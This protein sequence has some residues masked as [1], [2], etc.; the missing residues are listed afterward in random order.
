MQRLSGIHGLRAVAALSIVAFHV[1]YVPGFVTQPPILN[2]IIPQLGLGVPLF[3]VLSAFSLAY[4]HE[5]DVG[6]TG[7]VWPY[8]IKR[9]FRIGPLFWAMMVAYWYLG[10]PP[11]DSSGARLWLINATFI[12]NFFPGL[13][14]SGVAAGWSI[15]I[16]M[17]FY[18]LLPFILKRMRTP[19]HAVVFLAAS[20]VVSAASR[21]WLMHQ[22]GLPA[23]YY[24]MAF[25][26]YLA[27]F[28]FGL[29]AY[30]CFRAYE[31]P[32]V[33]GIITIAWLAL[34]PFRVVT[35]SYTS[36]P[37]D[38]IFWSGFFGLLTLW[39]AARPLRWLASAPMQWLGE[40]SFSI[41][42]LHPLV[43]FML[44]RHGVAAAIWQTLEP[45]I[46]SWAYMALAAL[47][48]AI[49]IPAAGLTY[50]LIEQPGQKLGS[51][52]IAA[53]RSATYNNA[54]HHLEARPNRARAATDAN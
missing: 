16:E 3:F 23:G 52:I 9:L 20:V 40:R 1:A 32:R 5:K 43:I 14:E 35:A 45:L 6:K 21:Y 17:P 25:T 48:F 39:Q 15:G 2:Q 30:Q 28:A 13:H 22:A 11:L 47:A 8:L 4:S 26:S 46:G 7:W 37:D 51:A 31:T 18:L 42:L 34:L 38:I 49:V 50:L 44:I 24:H 53:I 12:F 29:L 27:T 54:T 36:F 19:R 10:F 41:Y 33:L